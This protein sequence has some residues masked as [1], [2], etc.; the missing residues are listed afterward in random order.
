MRYKKVCI[1]NSCNKE[2]TCNGGCR[3]INPSWCLERKSCACP[4]CAKRNLEL[5]PHF[6]DESGVK[7]ICSRFSKRKTF[8]YR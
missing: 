8:V 1:D 2:F 7:S 5:D 6:Y 4:E 3:V